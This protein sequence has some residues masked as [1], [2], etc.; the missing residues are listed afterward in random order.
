MWSRNNDSMPIGV[1]HNMK[2]QY[3]GYN[4]FNP[5]CTL[6]KHTRQ[7]HNVL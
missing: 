4:Y 7:K 2:L 1:L 5:L 6:H 3:E